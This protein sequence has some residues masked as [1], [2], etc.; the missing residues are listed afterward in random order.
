MQEFGEL[1]T[2]FLTKEVVTV[3]AAIG[4]AWIGWKA[5]CKGT[6]LASGFASK[7]SFAGL[8]AASLL[9]VG[10]G[11]V[12]VGV[13]ELASRTGGEADALQPEQV[14]FTNKELMKL[15]QD[16]DMNQSVLEEVLKYTT[17]RD[18]AARERST[19]KVDADGNLW[20]LATPEYDFESQGVIQTSYSPPKLPTKP[21]D[22]PF[23]VA[24]VDAM[25]NE[26]SIMSTPMAVGSIFL[27]VASV[28]GSAG[29]FFT[30]RA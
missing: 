24:E 23:E 18:T 28:I 13:G 5:A 22:L 7:A 9:F 11:G 14:Q 1:I 4:V 20:V 12:G 15:A 6:Q 2:P 27:G 17:A 29:V 8:T 30:R 16:T 21:Q 3:I 26:E 25:K 10:M 19:Q